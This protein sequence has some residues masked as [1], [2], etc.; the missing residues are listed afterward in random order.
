MIRGT[1]HYHST[2][3]HDG[4]N[5]LSEIASALSSA[6]LQ[7]SVMTE[8]FED[9]DADK[10]SRCVR[11]MNAVTRSTGFVMVPGM[12]VDLSGLHTILFPVTSYQD[13][14]SFVSGDPDA[15]RSMF[16]VLAHPSR[17]SFEEIPPHLA[18]YRI[19]GIELWNQMADGRHMPPMKFLKFVAE[20]PWRNQCRYFFGCDLHTSKVSA[21]NLL[22]ISDTHERTTDAIAAAL[23]EGE[24]V[25]SNSPT[26]VEY[27]NGSQRTDYDAWLQGLQGRSNY[28]AK[29]LAGVRS[30]LK[31]VYRSLPRSMRHSLNDMKNYVRDKV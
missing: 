23:S 9:F 13:L 21:A 2:Y 10:F 25:A 16:K 8:H 11:E 24:F 3:S 14:V 19:N 4:K 22:S 20:Q 27:R 5:T 30:F 18:K 29:V 26:G 17:Y 15:G 6:G 28:K 31:P 7:F 1:F 12:E